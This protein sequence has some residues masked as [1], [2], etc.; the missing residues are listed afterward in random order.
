MLPSLEVGG[1]GGLGAICTN[2]YK[3]IPRCG[4]FPTEEEQIAGQCGDQVACDPPPPPPPA[5]PPS[6]GGKSWNPAAEY[7][8]HYNTGF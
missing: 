2:F 6:S 7:N 1:G 3:L 8:I 4:F 5:P